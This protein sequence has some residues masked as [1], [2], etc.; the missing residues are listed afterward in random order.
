MFN[1]GDIIHKDGN[2]W[3]PRGWFCTCRILA[4]RQGPSGMR[5]YKYEIVGHSNPED[6]SEDEG[7][8]WI[9]TNWEGY[10]LIGNI[11]VSCAT[12][13]SFGLGDAA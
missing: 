2:V 4:A 12:A 3:S 1:K 8:K 11:P 5:E 7:K 9:G 6:I 13:L 10:K